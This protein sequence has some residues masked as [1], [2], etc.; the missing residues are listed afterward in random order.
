M[1]LLFGGL[2]WRVVWLPVKAEGDSIRFGVTLKD[3]AGHISQLVFSNEI[4]F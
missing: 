4:V 3:R 1:L 2:F